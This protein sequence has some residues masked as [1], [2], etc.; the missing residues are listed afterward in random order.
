MSGHKIAPSSKVKS[1]LFR[2]VQVELNFRLIDIKHRKIV[3]LGFAC[4]PSQS[5]LT[6]VSNCCETDLFPV[7]TGLMFCFVAFLT[8]LQI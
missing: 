3:G 1:L 2:W 6:L 7:G 5:V 4:Q 8:C